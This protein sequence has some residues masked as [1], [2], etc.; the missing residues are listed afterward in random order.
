MTA[1][2]AFVYAHPELAPFALFLGM[3]WLA[4]GGR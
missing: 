2:A 4:R 1:V 3:A